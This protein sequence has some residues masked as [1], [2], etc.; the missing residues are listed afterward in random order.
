MSE[1]LART[2]AR[3]E[4]VNLANAYD[5]DVYCLGYLVIEMMTGIPGVHSQKNL[6]LALERAAQGYSKKLVN[7]V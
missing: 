3:G 5:E 6:G 1:H 2:L 4:A 7:L